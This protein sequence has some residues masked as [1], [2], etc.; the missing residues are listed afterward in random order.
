MII[1]SC[2]GPSLV[3]PKPPNYRQGTFSRWPKGYRD[4][5]QKASKIAGFFGQVLPLPTMAKYANNNAVVIQRRCYT[6]DRRPP[7]RRKRMS[8]DSIVDFLIA[9]IVIMVV[10]LQVQI[11][12]LKKRV[13]GPSG[14]TPKS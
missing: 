14:E 6:T 5:H 11:L 1:Q 9:L 7:N 4:G 13:R 2:K 12:Q 10:A 3:V 8:T